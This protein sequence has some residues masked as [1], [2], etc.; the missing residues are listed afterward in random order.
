M[1]KSQVS[2]PESFDLL[3]QEISVEEFESLTGFPFPS[4]LRVIYEVSD[5]S[6]RRLGPFV[7]RSFS[8][9]LLDWRDIKINF[10]T[11]SME[12][13]AD[14]TETDGE[15]TSKIN[16]HTHRLPFAFDLNGNQVAY[17]L[18]PGKKG[19]AGQIVAIENRPER[20]RWIAGSLTEFIELLNKEHNEKNSNQKML[21]LTLLN[22]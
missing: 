21:R 6:D 12:D 15:L 22:S 1:G 13:L 14:F 9:L 4:E 16:C 20:V 5:N 8:N 19:W 17:D 18:I 3:L 2:A 7:M 10:D 11:L